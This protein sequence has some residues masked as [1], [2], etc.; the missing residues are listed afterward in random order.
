[1]SERTTLVALCTSLALPTV[2]SLPALRKRAAD[3]LLTKA[4]LEI[5]ASPTTSEP[6]AKKP[7]R[8]PW[9]EFVKEHKPLLVAAGW[10][11][12]TLLAELRRQWH[13][14]KDKSS[15]TSTTPLLLTYV[16]DSADTEDEDEVSMDKLI[17]ALYAWP[18]TSLTAE[19][20]LHGHSTSGSKP[21][22]I[23]RLATAMLAA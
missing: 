12:G 3:A 23:S 17:D 7:R 15:D 6:A 11:K 13:D 19:L 10:K 9:L 14:A 1:M 5:E 16:S 20:A 4:M 18:V 22:L 8:N 2:G 21:E